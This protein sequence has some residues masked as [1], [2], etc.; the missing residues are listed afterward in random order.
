MLKAVGETLDD[1]LAQFYSASNCDDDDDAVVFLLSS[2]F[3]SLCF[4]FV[5]PRISVED[6]KTRGECR[7]I[8]EVGKTKHTLLS[9]S[10]SK[11]PPLAVGEA[12]SAMTV[13]DGFSRLFLAYMAVLCAT[14][15]CL[16]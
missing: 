5:L 14:T 1:Q 4:C 6:K 9:L 10:E 8:R 12:E 7:E 13:G 15:F 11:L 2:S 3:L 16:R